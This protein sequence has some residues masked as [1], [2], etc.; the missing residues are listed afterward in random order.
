VSQTVT[1]RNAKCVE[2]GHRAAYRMNIRDA[3]TPYNIPSLQNYLNFMQS[4]FQESSDA[5]GLSLD[6]ERSCYCLTWFFNVEQCSEAFTVDN[7]GTGFIIL[8]LGD[9]HLLER[10]Q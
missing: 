6:S 4:C 1:T 3:C 5:E 8:L 10:A 2:Q 7:G 9:P